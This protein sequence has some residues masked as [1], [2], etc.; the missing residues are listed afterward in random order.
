MILGSSSISA[1]KNSAAMKNHEIFETMIRPLCAMELAM[2][3]AASP[4]AYR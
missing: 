3:W 4:F 2:D 1:L